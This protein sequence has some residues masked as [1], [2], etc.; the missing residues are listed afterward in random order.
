MAKPAVIISV[1]TVEETNLGRIF[2]KVWR[3]RTVPENLKFVN[4][5]QQKGN[6]KIVICSLFDRR[7]DFHPGKEVR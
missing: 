7:F 2:T 4:S 3:F 5:Y 6:Y 1:R